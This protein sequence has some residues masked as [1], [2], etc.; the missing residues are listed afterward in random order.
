MNNKSALSRD[1]YI[2]EESSL[3]PQENLYTIS[4]SF[5]DYFYDKSGYAYFLL[6][7]WDT[8]IVVS[9]DIPTCDLAGRILLGYPFLEKEKHTFSLSSDPEGVYAHK[10]VWIFIVEEWCVRIRI[11]DMIWKLFCRHHY[12]EW[13]ESRYLIRKEMT[14]STLEQLGFHPGDRVKCDYE[15]PLSDPDFYKRWPPFFYWWRKKISFELQKVCSSPLSQAGYF[16]VIDFELNWYDGDRGEGVCT[17]RHSSGIVFSTLIPITSACWFPV[18]ALITGYP[19][20]RP[21]INVLYPSVLEEGISEDGKYVGTIILIDGV[22]RL[23]I[24]LMMCKIH[25]THKDKRYYDTL[26][27]HEITEEELQELWHSIGD[28]VEFSWSDAMKIEEFDFINRT[29]LSG[30]EVIKCYENIFQNMS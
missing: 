26:T 7:H 1:E 16:F 5:I 6:I 23:R 25:S 24:W 11:G 3:F 14:I 4:D 2:I 17:L 18:P 28:R 8:A 20:I 13:S 22:P 27:I 29:F 9:A 12:T 21:E 19:I 10:I 15:T 30:F